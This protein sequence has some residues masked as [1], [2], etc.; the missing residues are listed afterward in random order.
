[1]KK[2]TTEE[3]IEKAKLVHGDK[4]DYSN[5]VYVNA[6]TKVCIICKE[7]GDFYQTPAKHLLGRGCHKCGGSK[8]LT[9]EEFAE[10]AKKEHNNKYDYSKANYINSQTSMSIICPIH[11]EFSQIPNNH[12]KGVGC[13]KC[14]GN[15]NFTKEEWIEKAKQVHGNR[16]DYNRVEYK[17]AQT[18]VCIICPI[19]GE[20]KQTANNHLIGSGCPYCK[21]DKIA[22]ALRKPTEDFI[23]RANK[24]HDNKYDYGK[25]EYKNA[26][27][28][29][30]II[31]PIHGEFEQT[32]CSHLRGG[33]CPKCAGNYNY[34]TEEWIEK[35]NRIQGNKYDYSKVEYID[36]KN[37]VC[38]ICQIHGEFW[39]TPV[40]HLSGYGCRKCAIQKQIEKQSSTKEEFIEKAKQVHGDRY[41]YSKVEYVNNRK[42]ICVTCKKHG[43]FWQTPGSHLGGVGCPICSESKL[44]KETA[45]LLIQ[46]GVK[47]EREKKFTWLKHKNQLFLDFYLPE[48]NI[49]IECQGEQHFKLSGYFGGIEKLAYTKKLD[50]LKKQLCEENNLPLH[51]INYNDNV[52][53]KLNEIISKYKTN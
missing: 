19:H 31:C 36:S 40:D 48:Y 17:N 46:Y 37:K 11:G 1:M 27:R 50:K 44:E 30:V 6:K 45:K 51:Y 39:Q 4:Y 47:Y 21:N 5:V 3:W 13:P 14:A 2:P 52:T 22:D 33:G 16:Y 26:R 23:E 9:K 38:I 12:L 8:K 34:T 53:E 24:E 7:H 49:V 20:F 42:K 25:I 41:E 35:A 15:Y 43:E 32:P 29:I 10:R 18:R 28:N